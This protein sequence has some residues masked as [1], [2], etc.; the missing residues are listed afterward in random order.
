[1][2]DVLHGVETIDKQRKKRKQRAIQWYWRTSQPGGCGQAPLHAL[3][4]WEAIA[5]DPSRKNYNYPTF[6]ER[7]AATKAFWESTNESQSQVS[8]LDAEPLYYRV[9]AHVGSAS[10]AHHEDCLHF[11]NPG[12]LRLLPRLLLQ[13]FLVHMVNRDQVQL[14]LQ[15]RKSARLLRPPVPGGKKS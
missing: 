5:N 6:R 10:K 11:C 7:D 12:P 1:L 8:I 15:K 4:E 2:H 9:D 14:R 13:S 3:D